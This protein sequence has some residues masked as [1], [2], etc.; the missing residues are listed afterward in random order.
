MTEEQFKTLES[1]IDAKIAF[2]NMA[3]TVRAEC[4]PI[5]N[6]KRARCLAALSSP[7]DGARFVCANIADAIRALKSIPPPPTISAEER[8]R[9]VAWLRGKAARYEDHREASYAGAMEI[10]ADA[11]EAGDHNQPEPPGDVGGEG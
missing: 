6:D 4:L 2:A 8:A 9:I 10:A 1:W 11:I 7:E 5:L 3:P